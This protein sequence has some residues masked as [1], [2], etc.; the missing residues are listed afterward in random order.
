MLD[1][2]QLMGQS[3]SRGGTPPPAV[4][5][6]PRP[7]VT[8]AA[9]GTRPP[10]VRR[11]AVRPWPGTPRPMLKGA[12]GARRRRTRQRRAR[13]A[14]HAPAGH[15]LC[16]VRPRREHAQCRRF[17]PNPAASGI[18]TSRC[19]VSASAPGHGSRHRHAPPPAR[20][21]AVR[22][23]PGTPRPMLKGAEGARRRRTPQRRARPA[24]HA[25]RARPS[26][27][28]ASAGRGP[29]QA[30]PR[31]EHAQCRRFAPNPAASGIR[32]PSGGG[33][34]RASATGRE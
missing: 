6:R 33:A 34:A 14:G 25:R 5:C 2:T 7:P 28:A 24:G 32:S 9:T 12:E 1:L 26:S 15:G 17:A 4:R 13:P 11:T 19:P 16:R 22:P 8:E 31:R 18:R 20:Q 27:V 30:R 29:R 23:R 21:T 10:P 3:V